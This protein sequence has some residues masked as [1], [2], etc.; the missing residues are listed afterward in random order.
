MDVGPA[1]RPAF[2]RRR[3]A[4]DRVYDWASVAAF[5]ERGDD[6]ADSVLHLTAAAA[7][8][9]QRGPEDMETLVAYLPPHE[10]TQLTDH[11]G[12]EAHACAGARDT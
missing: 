10:R 9:R 4:R 8:Q 1:A 12:A 5:S 2:L 7:L 11:L 3:V 6:E